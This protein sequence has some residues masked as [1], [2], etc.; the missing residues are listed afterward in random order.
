M[1]NGDKN[2]KSCT[3][4]CGKMSKHYSLPCAVGS[5]GIAYGLG[6]KPM[7][8][9]IIGAAGGY[10]LPMVVHSSDV[11]YAVVGA[12]VVGIGARMASV[13]SNMKYIGMGAGAVGGYYYADKSSGGGGGQHT[14]TPHYRIGPLH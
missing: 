3:S 9:A 11:Y 7:Y 2:C 12:G 14:N 13:S 5:G 6:V 8:S 4:S 1:C 10:V